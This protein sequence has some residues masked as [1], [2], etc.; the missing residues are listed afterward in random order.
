VLAFDVD[1]VAFAMHFPRC[2]P[3]PFSWRVLTG[4]QE[5]ILARGYGAQLA[6]ARAHAVCGAC[7]RAGREG[8]GADEVQVL[9]AS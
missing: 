7:E 4:A 9:I 6:R 1:T 5:A 8:A 2:V 3:T